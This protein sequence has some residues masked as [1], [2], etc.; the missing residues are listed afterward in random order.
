MINLKDLNKKAR[1]SFKRRENF[2]DQFDDINRFIRPNSPEFNSKT[3]NGDIR[4]EEVFDGSAIQDLQQFVS[5]LYS[6]TVAGDWFR[7]LP[8]RWMKD[9][10]AAKEYLEEVKKT[11]F[12]YYDDPETSF[13]LAIPEAYWEIG[14]YGTACVFQDY[15][16]GQ[17]ILRTY[18]LSKVGIEENNKGRVDE[19][20]I[21]DEWT[22]KQIVQEFGEDALPAGES[23]K[24][25]T[26]KLKVVNAVIPSNLRVLGGHNAKG[27]KYTSVYWLDKYAED[28]KVKPLRVS[29]YD[30][31][32]YHV[33]RWTKIAGETFGRGQGLMAIHDVR[34]L[35]KIMS[36]L[37]EA[38]E[39][40][41][42]PI[43]V[44]NESAIIGDVSMEP[45]DVIY[46]NNL[47]QTGKPIEQAFVHGDIPAGYEMLERVR[48]QV[49]DY[50]FVNLLIRPKKKERQTT[51]EIADDRD[52]M[53][54]QLAPMTSRMEKELF[55]PMIK[56][57][58]FL[59]DKK[60]LL[61]EPPNGMTV[62]DIKIFFTSPSARA[63]R[64]F[65]VAAIR[66]YAQIA[67]E[68]GTLDPRAVKAVDGVM[69]LKVVADELEVPSEAKRTLREI[70][71]MEQEEAEQLQA[72]RQAE[73]NMNNSAA[74]KNFSDAQAT[75]QSMAGGLGF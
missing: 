7:L 15:E 51:V 52:E 55:H 37:L 31:F 42:N 40:A 12:D 68:M 33:P 64:G 13:T 59:L 67:T 75:Q 58:I 29:G 6:H 27:K 3:V 11:L 17:L 35:Q 9:S 30:Q 18:P 45:G 50:F 56:R 60:E 43:I 70:E 71:A 44:A 48:E 72:E 34:C 46:V 25:D 16:D 39:K 21:E 23:D 32:P 10:P 14:A 2:D 36:N 24:K 65:K 8:P 63:Q 62:D 49:R 73:I 53:L 38:S 57:S 61:P 54:K 69:A 74:A 19:V 66:Q 28:E 1:D 41:V 20:F 47:G 22:I 4:M 26:D 5:G